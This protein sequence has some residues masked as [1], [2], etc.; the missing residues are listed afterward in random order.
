MPR[1][2]VTDDEVRRALAIAARADP[3]PS[4]T[5]PADAVPAAQSKADIAG[6]VRVT[7]RAL[8]QRHPGRSVEIRIPPYI[9]VQAIDG[10][11]HTRGTPPNVVETDARTWLALVSGRTTFADAHAAGALAASGT[12]ADLADFLPL[13][14]AVG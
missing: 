9:A 10:P 6:A 12:R 2:S 14:G 8:A 1:K 3:A 5:G 11:R 7:A 13:A 4:D